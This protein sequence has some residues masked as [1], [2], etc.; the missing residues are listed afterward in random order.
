MSIKSVLKV[1]LM[2]LFCVPTLVFAHT[3]GDNNGFMAGLMHPVNGYDHLLA[4]LSV[5]IISAQKGGRAIWTVPCLFVTAMIVG[6]VL[7]ANAVSF[8][9]V[10][11][12]IAIS[13]VAL[14]LGII[15]ADKS[16]LMMIMLFVF[17]FGMF[18]GHAHGMEMPGSASPVFYSFGFI[19]S[20]SLVHVAGVVIG[21]QFTRRQQIKKALT[22]IGAAVTGAGCFLLLQ[23]V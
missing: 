5:G 14:G 7:G 1:T 20:T 9:N 22:Y 2:V 21:Y 13:V 19:V 12:G 6:A 15:F 23:M 3:D 18:H 4:M 10:E 11:A 17:G 16:N 8:P